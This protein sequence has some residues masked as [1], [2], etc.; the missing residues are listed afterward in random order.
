V[1]REA[2]FQKPS[3][4]DYSGVYR[5]RALE[6]EA[7]E[8][9]QKTSFPLDNI[10]E[11][12]IEHLRKALMHGAIAFLIVRFTTHGIT[13]LLDAS[14]V[15][16]AYDAKAKGGRKSIP[17][18]VFEEQGYVIPC[19]YGAPVDYLQVLDQVYFV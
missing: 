15:V 2:Y 11:H 8:T 17:L 7:K 3:T 18:R 12:Q 5:G 19:S 13:Y 10:H 14:H 16:N 6:F 1:I 4:V 9:K